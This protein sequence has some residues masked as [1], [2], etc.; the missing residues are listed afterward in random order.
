MWLDWSDC[1]VTC[2]GGIRIRNR[3]CDTSGID[4]SRGTCI[5]NDVDIST[6]NN[7]LCAGMLCRIKR[8]MHFFYTSYEY[9]YLS[10]V[11]KRMWT[12]VNFS[13]LN[14]TH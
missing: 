3:T 11:K 14:V 6:C 1:S 9:I 13:T 7:D 10:E 2:N 4:V 5:G 12:F 8:S